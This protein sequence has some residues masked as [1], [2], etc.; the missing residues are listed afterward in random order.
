MHSCSRQ[1]VNLV[2]GSEQVRAKP[3]RNK[4]GVHKSVEGKADWFVIA[5][6]TLVLGHSG[7]SSGLLLLL[8]HY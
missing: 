1:T 7:A 5:F 2:V 3:T 8:R 6:R 4:H